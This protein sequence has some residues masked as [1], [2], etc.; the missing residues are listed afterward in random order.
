MVIAGNRFGFQ[1]KRVSEKKL[2]VKARSLQEI[3]NPQPDAAVVMQNFLEWIDEADL[4]SQ[5]KEAAPAFK[6]ASGEDIFPPYET[7]WWL[8]DFV[9]NSVLPADEDGPAEAE[10]EVDIVED[11]RYV[12]D[13]EDDDAESEDEAGADILD[14]RDDTDELVPQ[15]LNRQP[16]IA[17]RE[18]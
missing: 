9:R 12:L 16:F 11:D 8:L 10:E 1:P 15:P 5:R 4:A 14:L 17:W 3:L 6:T 13:D 18:K 2:P 7:R